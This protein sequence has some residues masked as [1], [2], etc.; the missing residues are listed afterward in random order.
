MKLEVRKNPNKANHRRPICD[1]CLKTRQW[2]NLELR[3]ERSYFEPY[4]MYLICKKCIEDETGSQ[5][6][7]KK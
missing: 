4:E 7:E 1:V 3:D 2:K 6:A 5:P